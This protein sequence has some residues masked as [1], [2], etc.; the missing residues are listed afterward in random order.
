MGA[1]VEPTSV[2]WHAASRSGVDGGT[3]LIAG[4]GAG[5]GAKILVQAD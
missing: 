4:A 5:A 1:L 2:A 3:T